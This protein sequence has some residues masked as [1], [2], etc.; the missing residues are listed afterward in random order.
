MATIDPARTIVGGIDTHLDV[1]VAAAVDPVGGLLGAKSFA[2]SPAG[3][4][5]LH[6]WLAGFGELAQ[7]GVE[8]T[9]YGAG[10]AR[11]LR[12]A[13][14]EVIEVDRPNRQARRKRGK[15]DPADAE[16]AARA[17]L[18]GRAVGR[19]KTKE[20]NV[21]AMSRSRPRRTRGCSVVGTRLAR[22]GPAVLC[23]TRR[24]PRGGPRQTADLLHQRAS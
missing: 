11:F 4:K 6:G 23:P 21:E 2:A 24:P 9:A 17:V 22:V 15:S 7:V 10:V 5:Q 20:G 8:G 14:V 19:P 1:H 16:E 12:R 13:G 3:C 18:S